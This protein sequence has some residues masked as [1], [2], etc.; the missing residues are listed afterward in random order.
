MSSRLREKLKRCGRY[1]CSPASA[2]HLQ[3]VESPLIGRGDN[4][5]APSPVPKTTA[6]TRRTEGKSENQ[7]RGGKRLFAVCSSGGSVVNTEHDVERTVSS[8]PKRSRLQGCEEHKQ[9][10]A[11]RG[12]AR[13]TEELSSSE[14]CECVSSTYTCSERKHKCA[15]DNGSVETVTCRAVKRIADQNQLETQLPDE[16]ASELQMLKC[17]H[18]SLQE[19]LEEKQETLRKLRMVKMYRTKVIICSVSLWA[20]HAISTLFHYSSRASQGPFVQNC[21]K[22]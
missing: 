7:P 3:V 21:I 10:W 12:E 15:S 16:N 14:G 22:T 8:C 1:H 19:S 13:S 11:D 17:L 2:K 9:L 5:V 18:A 20:T 6:R 4:S